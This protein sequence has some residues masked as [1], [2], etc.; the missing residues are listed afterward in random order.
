MAEFSPTYNEKSV[1]SKYEYGDA[2]SFDYLLSSVQEKL[3]IGSRVF[4]PSEIIRK[5]VL[6]KYFTDK[7][8]AGDIYATLEEL[9]LEFT[10]DESKLRSI[11]EK[12]T[13]IPKETTFGSTTPFNGNTNIA[14]RRYNSFYEE[15]GVSAISKEETAFNT[16]VRIDG[17]NSVSNLLKKTNEIFKE[18]K[19]NT[20]INRFSTNRSIRNRNNIFS[21][22]AYI[23][24]INYI[25]KL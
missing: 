21:I 6:K 5:E 8:N 7:V 19:T 9:N 12:S 17:F 25:T 4:K 11:E 18:K 2:V 1:L 22:S 10:P 14:G 15:N 23:F 24:C 16:L 13:Y 3:T 20:L